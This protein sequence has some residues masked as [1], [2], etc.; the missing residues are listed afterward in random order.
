MSEF[1]TLKPEMN[2]VNNADNEIVNIKEIQYPTRVG[3]FV[4]GSI[5]ETFETWIGIDLSTI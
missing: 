1:K 3:F 2:S 4:F 5:K